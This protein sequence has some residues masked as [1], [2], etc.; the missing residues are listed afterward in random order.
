MNSTVQ[1]RKCKMVSYCSKKCQKQDWP[2]HEKFCAS[3]QFHRLSI[4]DLKAILQENGV[5]YKDCIEKK[6]LIQKVQQY[7]P[8]TFVFFGCPM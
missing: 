2:N 8:N 4:S 1:C 7:C 6:D 3:K 5:D